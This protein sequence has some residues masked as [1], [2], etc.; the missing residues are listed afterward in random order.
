MS[1]LARSPAGGHHQGIVFVVDDDEDLLHSVEDLLEDEG[2]LVL[3]ARDGHEALSRMRG[4]SGPSAAVVD[5]KMPGMDGWQL[6]HAMKADANLAEIPIV[7]L[8]ADLIEPL[9]GTQGH[10]R[11]PIKIQ[12]LLAAVRTS[13]NSSK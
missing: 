7:T 13:L 12:T 10:L 1:A 8:S 9:E 2:Y 4:I 3:A 11:K 5:L 6:V